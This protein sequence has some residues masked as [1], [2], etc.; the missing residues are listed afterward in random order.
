MG[1]GAA[2][3]VS[4]LYRQVF[5]RLPD[6]DEL[7]LATAFIRRDSAADSASSSAWRVMQA[8]KG[9]PPLAL[10]EQ[11]AQVLLLTNEFMFVD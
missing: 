9:D 7:A 5:G 4:R 10:W 6:P 3:R 8:L 1:D 2:G 11:L